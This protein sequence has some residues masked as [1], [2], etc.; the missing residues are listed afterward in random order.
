MATHGS[1]LVKDKRSKMFLNTTHDGHAEDAFEMLVRLP[2]SIAS[3]HSYIDRLYSRRESPPTR[4][5]LAEDVY[6]SLPFEWCL[7]TVSAAIV[8]EHFNR[9]LVIPP[10]WIK[11]LADYDKKPDFTIDITDS[12]CVKIKIADPNEDPEWFIWVKESI[13]RFKAEWPEVQI[14]FNKDVVKISYADLYVDA[15]HR[16]VVKSFVQKNLTDNGIIT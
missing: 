6:H 11:H 1:I 10:T 7:T 13:E 8:C 2:I 5:K 12:Y 4:E 16:R 14:E 3:K 9:W 15:L